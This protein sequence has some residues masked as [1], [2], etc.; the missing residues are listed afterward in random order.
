MEKLNGKY[1]LVYVLKKPM[2][3]IETRV[4]SDDIPA[5][6][7]RYEVRENYLRPGIWSEIASLVLIF[8]AGSLLSA[9][10]IPVKEDEVT[11][12]GMIFKPIKETDYT[13]TDEWLTVEDYNNKYVRTESIQRV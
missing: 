1:R 11:P 7:I 13:L 6:L 4:L 8:F 12:K 2:L 9:D 3:Y 10:K 5:G